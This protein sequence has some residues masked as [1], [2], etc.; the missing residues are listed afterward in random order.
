MQSVKEISKKISVIG[1]IA[2]QTNLLALN[3]AVEAARAGNQGKGFSVVASE[4]RKLAESSKLAANQIII[5]TKKSLEKTSESESSFDKIAPEIQKSNQLVDEIA[6]ASVDQ[7]SE[8]SQVNHSISQ[9]NA[10]IQQNAAV[11]EEISSSAEELSNQ[12]QH[13]MELVAF[14]KISESELSH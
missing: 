8:A 1:D 11:A 7:I 4:V 3:A 12:A 9:M 6:R 2:F 10:S 13:L 14:F 5:L